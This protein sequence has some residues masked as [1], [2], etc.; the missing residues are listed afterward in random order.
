MACLNN[1]NLV[2]YIHNELSNSEATTFENHTQECELCAEEIISTRSVLY[3]ISSIGTITP[4]ESFKEKMALCIAKERQYAI[5]RQDLVAYI[6][7]ELELEERE[8]IEVA[9][10]DDEQLRTELE[11]YKKTLA[12]VSSIPEISMTQNSPNK[13][14]RFASASAR[15]RHETLFSWKPW[16]VSIAAN[17]LIVLGIMSYVA[18]NRNFETIINEDPKAVAVAMWYTRC[19]APQ[20]KQL[21]NTERTVLVK[22]LLP[23]GIISL[24][25]T[26]DCIEVWE[27]KIER[28]DLRKAE[29]T[30]GTL[31]IDPAL[32]QK[33]F[34]SETNLTLVK[35]PTHLEL[36]GE[37]R[38]DAYKSTMPIQ[39][40]V[41]EKSQQK[42][43]LNGILFSVVAIRCF[44]K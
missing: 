17:I 29:I 18:S 1:K 12:L 4:S 38:F 27:T 8:K 35:M 30:S 26:N 37:T 24:R 42:I 20:T 13:T 15:F 28:K 2:A 36:W 39:I 14:R 9:L 34:A 25:D 19:S 3:E 33:H 22:S 44:T 43:S 5:L 31:K 41:E 32:F 7:D 21:L 6:Y 10:L 16:V 11:E 23:D 40:E